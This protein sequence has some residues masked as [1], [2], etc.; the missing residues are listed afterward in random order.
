MFRNTCDPNILVSI[1]WYSFEEI[2]QKAT[3]I[4]D[5]VLPD[6]NSATVATDIGVH[7]KGFRTTKKYIGVK[8][9]ILPAPRKHRVTN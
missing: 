3:S 5:G 6:K 2:F 7:S 9:S 4:A 8:I 1:N